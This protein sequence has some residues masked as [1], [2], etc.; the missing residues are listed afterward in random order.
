MFYLCWV[1]K[2]IQYFCRLNLILW[3]KVRDCS[4]LGVRYY[5][6]TLYTASCYVN[7]IYAF[8]YLGSLPHLLFVF[9]VGSYFSFVALNKILEHNLLKNLIGLLL[10]KWTPFL[11]PAEFLLKTIAFTFTRNTTFF[12]FINAASLSS[13]LKRT[14][15]VVY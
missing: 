4:L 14:T 5:S 12:S 11:F 1:C 9:L 6:S 7:F 15:K 13:S 10:S 2:F 3:P 8:L